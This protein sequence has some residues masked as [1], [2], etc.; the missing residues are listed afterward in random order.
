MKNGNHLSQGPASLEIPVIGKPRLPARIAMVLQTVAVALTCAIAAFLAGISWSHTGLFLPAPH[1]SPLHNITTER[2]DLR[3][4]APTPMFYLGLAVLLVFLLGTAYAWT[5]L[6]PKAHVGLFIFVYALAACLLWVLAL[7]ITGSAFSYP[8]STSLIQS[9]NSLSLGHFHDFAPH[10]AGHPTFY[11]YY[12]WYPF[13]TGGLLWFTLIFLLVGPGNLFALLI[14]NAILTASSVWAIWKVSTYIGLGEKGQRVTALLLAVNVPLL[15]SAGFIYTNAAGLF[16]VLLAVLCALQA[17]RQQ[18]ALQAAIWTFGAFALGALAMLIKGTVVLFV[19][20]FVLLLVLSA[21]RKRMY[22]LIALDIILFAAAHWASGLSLP[23]V[24]HIVGQKFGGGLPQLSWIAIGLTHSGGATWMPGWWDASAIHHYVIYKG[25]T[26]LQQ[27]A[28]QDTIRN[29]INGFTSDPQS[30]GTFF[31]QK[32]AS[33][34]AEP[35]YQSLLYSSLSPRRANSP[36]VG[37]AMFGPSSQLLVSFTNVYQF[38]LYA[39]C[40]I[41]C[42]RGITARK[43]N[44]DAFEALCLNACIIAA[45]FLCF[46]LWEAKSV[47]VFPFAAMMVPLAGYGLEWSY[48]ATRTLSRFITSR[49]MASK[50]TQRG[51]DESQGEVAGEGGRADSHSGEIAPVSAPV[52]QQGVNDRKVDTVPTEQQSE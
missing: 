5:K 21:I 19:L 43:K 31:I 38:L 13:Q 46:L 37:A 15:M 33:E 47:Y 50:R 9:A 1:A 39:F 32:L 7:N 29:A 4:I 23:L 52:E 40:T 51:G 34:W 22:W 17:M 20:A 28:A 30:A 41:G 18:D 3:Q 6:Q 27:Q 45:G 10:G 25:N 24:E 2:M 35:T 8:D 11:S 49:F 16:F 48:S 36:L 44:R 26:A 42:I 12:S 14:I